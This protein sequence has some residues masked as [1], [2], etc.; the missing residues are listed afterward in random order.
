MADATKGTGSIAQ[1]GGDKPRTPPRSGS[2]SF[3]DAF[4]K[5]IVDHLADGVYYVDRSRSILYWNEGAEHLTGYA[6][7]DVVGRPCNDGILAHVDGNGEELCVAVCPLLASIR[8]D[9]PRDAQVWLR[10]RDGHR[11]P[12]RVR[13]APIHD[14][15]GHVSG[16]VEIFDDA[17]GLIDAREEAAAASRDAL[18]DALTGLPNRRQLDLS[19]AGRLENLN[20]YGWRFALLIADID[21]FK[22][23][24]DEHGHDAGD[25]ALS[26]VASTIAGGLRKGDM[27]ARWG[28]EEFVILAN[29]GDDATPRALAERIRALVASSVV[30]YGGQEIVV[31]VSIGVAMAERGDEARGLLA[32]ADDALYRAKSGGRDRVVMAEEGSTPRT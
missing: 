17:T 27:A 14:G 25:A 16:A 23:V 24:N 31:R 30:H 6:A 12:V 8:D 9:A 10:H 20:R 32:R 1:L 15:D 11:V 7:Q 19:L 3:A 2:E 5:T 22:A 26:T 13:T 18:T 4:H 29:A 28:G 21:H